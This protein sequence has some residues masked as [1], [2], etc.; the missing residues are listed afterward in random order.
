[1]RLRYTVHAL[2]HI[3]AIHDYIVERNPAAAA[4]VIGRIRIAADR[5]RA[6]PR[7]GRA[8]AAAGTYEW[9]VRDLPYIVVYEVDHQE[10]EVVVLAVFHGAQD[11]RDET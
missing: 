8:G 1:M 4:Q 6:F 5:L 2:G 7:I 9:V 3:K 10:D 11:R